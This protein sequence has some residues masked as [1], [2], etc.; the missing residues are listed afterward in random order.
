MAVSACTLVAGIATLLLIAGGIFVMR[1]SH[2]PI[3]IEGLG[4]RIATALDERFG[5]GYHFGLGKTAITKRGYGPTLGI[6]GLSLRGGNGQTIF[7]APYAEVSVDPL[8]LVIGKVT[9]RRLEILN[10]EIKLSVLPNGGLAV[11]TGSGETSTNLIVPP[12]PAL[13]PPSVTAVEPPADGTAKPPR[14]ILIKQA[15]AAMRLVIDTL[16]NPDSAIAAIDHIGIVRGRLVIDDRTTDETTVFNDL[17]LA[18]DKTGGLTNFLLSSEG[19]N[20]RWK[21]VVKASGAPGAER[22]LEI[23][24]DNLTLDEISLASGVRNFGADFDMPVSAQLN[25]ALTPEGTISQAAGQFGMKAGYFRLDDPDHE[26]LLIDVIDGHFHWEPS[27][28]RVLLDNAR[29]KAGGSQ[30]TIAGTMTP[31]VLEGEA[32]ALNFHLVEPGIYGAER[33]GELP[34]KVERGELSARLLPKDKSLL[35]DKLSFTGADFG[36][37][38]TGDIDWRNGPRVRLGASIDPSPV[39]TIVRMWPSFIAAPVR[40]WFLAHFDGG[41]VPTGTLRVDYDAAALKTMRAKHPPPDAS[42]SIDFTVSNGSVNFLPGVPSLHD[43]TGVA[44]I[45]GKTSIFLVSNGVLD[46]DSGHKLSLTEGSF[47]I[48][49]ASLKPTPAVLIAKVTGPVDAVRELLAYDALKPYASMPLDSSA[50]TMRGQVDGRLEVDLKIDPD[51][52]PSDPLILINATATNL[53]VEKLIGKEKLDAATLSV[54]VDATGLR[55]N[56]QGRMFGVPA[57]LE[58]VRPMGAKAAEATLSFTTD[59]AARAKQGFAAIPGISGPIAT[60]IT[61]ALGSADK[62][63][64]QVELDL[65]KATLDGVLPGVSKP[66]GMAGKASFSITSGDEALQIDQIALD[67]GPVQLRGF[68]EIGADQSLL[69]AR[70]S[71]ARLSPGDDMKIDI[72]KAGDTMKL[73]VHATTIDARPFLKPFSFSAGGSGA[74]GTSV[75]NAPAARRMARIRGFSRISTSN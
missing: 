55:A 31:P 75:T 24:F 44:H 8:A 21:A 58:L 38:M 22:H 27:T 26:P 9:P 20:G 34:I 15:A 2:S 4:P 54:N 3:I 28:R 43:V 35:I 63:K 23:G 6:E 19:P 61:A 17:E 49:D 74:G 66:A 40:A 69:S 11:S 47:H 42:T 59:D 25:V 16:T 29:L 1:L 52:P 62:Q 51:L 60:R 46:T 45:S 65:T 57:T 14:A 67:M 33:P 56:G 50:G 39:R 5:R 18:F 71:Q 73:V 64:A 48:P 72:S 41:T 10:V 37:A 70:F 68:A 36:I 13:T 30:F 53:V 32:F 7:T 12:Q